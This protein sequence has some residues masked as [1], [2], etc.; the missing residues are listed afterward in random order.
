MIRLVSWLH[1]FYD[2]KR[3]DGMRQKCSKGSDRTVN[4]ITKNR[5]KDGRKDALK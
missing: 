4:M 1:G 3:Q 2:S 5:E